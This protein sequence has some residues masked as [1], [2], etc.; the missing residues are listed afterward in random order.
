MTDPAIHEL[1]QH[2]AALRRLARDLVGA[3]NADDVLQD[4]AV[5]VLRAGPREPGPGPVVAW[6]RSVVRHVASK[7]NRADAVRRQHENAAAGVGERAFVA[8]GAE[9]ADTLRCLTE[10]VTALPEPYRS[11]VLAR[12]LQ[13]LTPNEIAAATGVPVRTVKT[14]L[15]RGLQLLRE[16]GEQRGGD[17]R[18]ALAFAFGLDAKKAAVVATAAVATGVL[19]MGATAKVTMVAVALLVVAFA[20][21]QLTGPATSAIPPARAN[22]GS[23]RAV[24]TLPSAVAAVPASESPSA[25]RTPASPAAP[26]P[27]AKAKPDE[28]GVRVVD[29]A[30]GQP[31]MAYGLREHMSPEP[32]QLGGKSL[33]LLHAGMHA[34]GRLILP[35][36]AFD[37]RAFVV[38]DAAGW[39]LPS[40]WF[41]ATEAVER[42]GER[43]IEVRL[44]KPME[45]TV[46]VVHER[47]GEAVVGTR[48][49]L[50]RPW[51]VPC[52]ISVKTNAQPSASFRAQAN[53][54]ATILGILGGRALLL[55]GAPTGLDGR[56][57]LR[58][59]PGESLVLR[60]L[61]P[62]H[63]PVVHSPWNLTAADGETVIET[64]ST[65]SAIVVRVVPPQ[66]LDSLRAIK[67]DPNMVGTNWE[68]MYG[69]G[70]RLRNLKTGE[71]RPP[72]IGFT[73]VPIP[74][75][76]D[77]T[78]RVDGLNPGDWEVQFC[79][80]W[81]PGKQGRNQSGLGLVALPAATALALA[82]CEVRVV[83]VDI[84]GWA[85]GRLDATVTMDG[86]IDQGRALYVHVVG[87]TGPPQPTLNSFNLLPGPD[88][89]V[90][91]TLPPARYLLKDGANIPVGEFAIR[92]DETTRVDF[93]VNLVQCRL[94]VVEA[95]GATPAQ[96]AI[97]LDRAGW[98]GN[99]VTDEAGT[100][101][102]SV[103]RDDVLRT[104][105]YRPTGK[106]AN[107]E[108]TYGPPIDLGSLR[109][110]AD[111]KP[112]VLRLPA[113]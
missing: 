96:G 49:E 84:T 95:D 106:G 8:A 60:L 107:G 30:S 71:L 76:A 70:V 12:Y 18:G 58:V 62:G 5:E 42:D 51:I 44:P 94:Q 6:L 66:A 112:I 78:C 39:Y 20:A 40:R 91:A 35:A 21:W 93:I 2:A 99:A 47:T 88:G 46:R 89:H 92:A 110:S 73:W 113:R 52:E 17:W 43:S 22:A 26:S 63:R 64:V 98:R 33:P 109:A 72:A 111:G 34:D 29:A 48:V 1:H 28:I 104:S 45:I 56:C 105:F 86:R 81:R 9:A 85:C 59:P 103:L 37:Q 90:R 79:Y 10:W 68:A 80:P 23:D 50:L 4:A 24:A 74:F 41:A 55:D 67:V 11:T 53:D 87:S 100:A 61:G 101:T 36:A 69:L 19:T 15:Q 108:L 16:R 13:E 7:R 102:A 27:V 77:A 83:D 32:P 31:V 25:E 82:D 38:E 14:R 3:S 97:T 75:A 65:G 54:N 57:K